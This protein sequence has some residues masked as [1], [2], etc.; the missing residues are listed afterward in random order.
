L[1]D[2]HFAVQRFVQKAEPVFSRVRGID[3]SH[4]YNVQELGR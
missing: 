2:D 3:I 1:N 4:V